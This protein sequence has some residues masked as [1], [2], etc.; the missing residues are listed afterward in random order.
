LMLNMLSLKVLQRA[1]LQVVPMHERRVWIEVVKK[2][3]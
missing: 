1:D 2:A 3:P